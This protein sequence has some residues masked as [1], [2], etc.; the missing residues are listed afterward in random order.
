MALLQAMSAGVPSIVT[1][2]GGMAEVVGRSGGGL[3]TPVGDAAHY[4]DAI[5]RMA[6]DPGLRQ[7]LAGFARQSYRAEFTLE[8]MEAGYM[9][10]YRRGR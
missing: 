4:A 10:I 3:L 6:Y 1:D 8:R 9:E 2:V 5:V 7:Q